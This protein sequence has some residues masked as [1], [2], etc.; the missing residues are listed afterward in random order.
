[1]ANQRN[2][3]AELAAEIENFTDTIP[4]VLEKLKN[5]EFSLPNFT[6]NYIWLLTE[7]NYIKVLSGTYD[8]KK[9][10][11]DIYCEERGVDEY[12]N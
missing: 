6:A 10:E 9:S 4:T 2:K 7:D 5:V 3:L 1:M 8:K 12:G 11:W